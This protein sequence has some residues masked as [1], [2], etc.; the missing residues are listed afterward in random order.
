[1]PAESDGPRVD[2]DATELP[3]EPPVDQRELDT[4]IMRSSAWAVVGF[5]G[6][7]LL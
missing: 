1:V 4:K 2:L 7:N 6:T 3:T 5:G